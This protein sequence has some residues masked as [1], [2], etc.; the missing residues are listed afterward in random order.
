MD[1][2]LV[3]SFFVLVTL[4]ILEFM[5]PRQAFRSMEV[6]VETRDIDKTQAVLRNIS[7]SKASARSFV[8]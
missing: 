5:E 4:T 6:C 8:N 3:L 1:L 7:Q 2:A